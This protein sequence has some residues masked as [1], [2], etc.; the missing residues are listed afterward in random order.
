VTGLLIGHGHV[1]GHLIKPGLIGGPICGQCD[2]ETETASHIQSECEAL[3]ELR[4]CGL[5]KY[6]MEL[7]DFD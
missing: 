5:G 3:A 6:F 1:K 7:S 4:F 2:T